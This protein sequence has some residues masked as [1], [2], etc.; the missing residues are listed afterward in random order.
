MTGGGRAG[1]PQGEL[2]LSYAPAAR[3]AVSASVELSLNRLRWASARATLAWAGA[4]HELSFNDRT[5]GHAL[6]PP[7]SAC[8]VL[9]LKVG[10]PI[11]HSFV[12]HYADPNGARR[13]LEVQA[14]TE[15]VFRVLFLALRLAVHSAQCNAGRPEP[16]GPFT[17]AW[18]DDL[19]IKGPGGVAASPGG[20][21]VRGSEGI[22]ERFLRKVL[23]A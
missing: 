9:S 18:L 12:V 17:P 4:G 7:I 6:S 10:D 5:H 16:A 2:T 11:T 22:D 19:R 20:R 14:G 15:P 23:C 8:S 3:D 1:G 21:Y 13:S